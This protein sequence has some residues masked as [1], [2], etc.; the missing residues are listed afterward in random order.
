MARHV[1]TIAAFAVVVAA[2][3]GP[4]GPSAGEPSTTK[5]GSVT[6]ATPD[7]FPPVPAVFDG[8]LAVDAQAALDRA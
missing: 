7:A 1:S 6:T 3:A 4:S 5:A 8:P 2:C